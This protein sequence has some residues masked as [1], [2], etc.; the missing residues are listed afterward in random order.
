[1]KNFPRNY[2][3]LKNTDPKEF[4]AS[5]PK[6][7]GNHDFDKSCVYSIKCK[8]CGMVLIWDFANKEYFTNTFT[9]I[10]LTCEEVLMD[11]AL[12]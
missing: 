1:M 11:Q 8:K 9:P 4:W 5:L 7:P 2:K 12:K 3:E 6:P 10:S